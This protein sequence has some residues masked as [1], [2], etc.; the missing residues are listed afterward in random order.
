VIYVVREAPDLDP[1][2]TVITL[3][4]ASEG[5]TYPGAFVRWVVR[6]GT[7][8]IAGFGADS[9]RIA[10]QTAPGGIYFVRQSVASSHNLPQST[11]TKVN[12]EDGRMA[13]TRSTRINA[14]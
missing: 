13:V 2:T 5:L 8:E 7:H 6:P 14:S 11:F 9:G 10:L 3:N 4:G 12:E 1:R